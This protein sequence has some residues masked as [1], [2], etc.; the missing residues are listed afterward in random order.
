MKHLIKHTLLVLVI[1]LAAGTAKAQIGYNYSQYDIG[2]GAGMS[3]VY[4]DAQT[5]VSS[6]TAHFTFTYNASPFVN[7]V[8]EV[9]AGHLKGGDSLLTTT[10]RQFNNH[11]T[12]VIFRGQ[13][14]AGE[15]IDYSNSKIA[16]AF[17]NLYISTGVGFGI[18]HLATVSRNAILTPGFYT[19]GPDNSTELLIPARVGYEFK[20]FNRYDI[21]TFKVD[22]AYQH[23]F[24]LGDGLDGY[25]VG[26]QKDK[27]S[28][29]T[30]GVKFAIGAITSYKKQ[31]PY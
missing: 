19:G 8:L 30:L 12:A 21:P 15:I 5:I 2:L 27:Y 24:M 28:Q 4:G 1:C 16:N 31:I 26:A 14:Q 18:S 23:N 10:G 22:I 13:L 7:Y 6:P 3:K 20:L 11:F 25:E 9:Q 17:K 29:F